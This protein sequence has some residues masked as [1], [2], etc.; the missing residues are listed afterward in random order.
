MKATLRIKTYKGKLSK[1]YYKVAYFKEKYMKHKGL[2][3]KSEER[4][5]RIERYVCKKK[6][7]EE[8]FT[9]GKEER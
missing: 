9:K 8:T 3:E 4:G 7:K 5:E 2:P 1:K 6:G